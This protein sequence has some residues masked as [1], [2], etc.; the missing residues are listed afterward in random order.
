MIYGHKKAE[1]MSRDGLARGNRDYRR[2]SRRIARSTLRGFLDGDDDADVTLDEYAQAHRSDWDGYAYCT[3][4]FTMWAARTTGDVAEPKS[5]I[6]KLRKL[7]PD[8]NVQYHLGRAVGF[9]A[10]W[11]RYP[12]LEDKASH[13]EAVQARR[14]RLLEEIVQSGWGHRLLNRAISHS[15]VVWEVW[16]K[17]AP[18]EVPDG[19][20]HRKKVVLRDR[21]VFVRK[22]PESARKL[23]G[24]G[25]IHNFLHD[26]LAA[27]QNAVVEVEPYTIQVERPAR[28]YCGSENIAE[29]TYMETRIRHTR[30]NPDYHPEW[31][32]SVDAFL[33]AWEAHAGDPRELRKTH[34]GKMRLNR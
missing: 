8:P 31:L 27:S 32:Q 15:T 17:D 23:L 2:P 28:I 5:R 14:V 3:S 10:N 20:S 22:G 6:G 4:A 11:S 29:H 34:L 18:T 13:A 16:T 21:L 24:L 12:T 7:V 9:T 1:Q 19:V 25:D 26:I 30:T 33:N